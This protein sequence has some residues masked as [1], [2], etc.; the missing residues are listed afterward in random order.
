MVMAGDAAVVEALRRGDEQ[1]FAEVVERF[2]PML[3][4]I[5]RGYVRTDEAVGDVV[6]ETWIAVLRGIDRF[7]GRSSL[8]TWVVSILV[9]VARSLAVKEARTVPFTSLG[10]ADDGVA[11]FGPERFQGPDGEY[12]GHWT[13]PPTPWTED[14]EASAL[15]G[16]TRA[17]VAQAVAALPESQR[18]VITLRDV[19]GWTGPEVAAALGISEGNQR[20]LLHRARA[21]VRLALDAHLTAGEGRAS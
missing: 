19:D 17:V 12:P 10:P 14:P 13:T 20:V 5:A 6:Q 7:E 9:N 18:A 16:E 8:R 2:H 4:R 21:K 1:A 15:A 3:R 11:G